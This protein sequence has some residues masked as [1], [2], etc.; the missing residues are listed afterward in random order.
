MNKEAD[1]EIPK[2]SYA[3]GRL[4]RLPRGA[5]APIVVYING[6]VQAEG[7]DYSVRDNEVLFNRDIV[8]EELSFMRKAAMFF[9]F[10][11]T[12]RKHETIDIQFRLNG[13]TELAADVKLTE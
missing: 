3:A 10:F 13:K 1:Q 7:E 2:G 5:Q 11:G 6:L 8:K 9:S 4:V 12:Y